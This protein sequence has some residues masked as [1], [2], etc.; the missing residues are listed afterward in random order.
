MQKLWNSQQRKHYR[1]NR[2]EEKLCEWG[3]NRRQSK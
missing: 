1:P 2:W 3:G